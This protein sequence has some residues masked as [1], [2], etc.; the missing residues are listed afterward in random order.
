MKLNKESRKL[1]RQLFRS[2]FQDGKLDASKVSDVVKAIVTSKQRHHLDIIK[3]Y[4]RLIRL[5]IEKRHAI[6]ESAL[7]LDGTT[8][9]KVEKDLKK[10]Y[11]NDLT[12]EF[13]VNPDLIGGLRIKLGNDVWDG[14][15]RNRLARL[16]E[17]LTH[18]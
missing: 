14:S 1:S 10:K 16:E 5:E 17:Q 15:V 8:C 2:S 7:E 12:A 13:K 4:Q 11:G 3:N 6:I 18:V 9:E